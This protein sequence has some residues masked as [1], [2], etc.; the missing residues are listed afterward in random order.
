MVVKNNY[1][2][3]DEEDPT[4]FI[5]N[6]DIAEVKSIRKYEE[7]Y[8]FRFAEMELKFPDYDLEIESKVMLDVL[9]LDSPAL[10]SDRSSELF[11]QCFSRLHS[12]ENKEET[13]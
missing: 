10:P 7:I 1:S 4:R 3:A 5:A 2:L 12:S 6:G 11:Q 9:Q 13:V 8:G